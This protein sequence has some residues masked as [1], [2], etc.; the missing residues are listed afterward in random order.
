[1]DRI[2]EFFA[3]IKRTLEWLPIVWSLNDW[4][5]SYSLKVF[6]FQLERQKKFMESDKAV[7]ADRKQVASRIGTALRLMDKVYED[8]YATEW[9]DKVEDRFGE[10]T[11][12]TVFLE[13]D[14]IDP[15]KER[16]YTMKWAFEKYDDPMLIDEIEFFMSQEVEKARQ[17]QK[18]AERLLWDFIHWNIRNW[19]D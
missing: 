19:W 6:R 16:L 3:R 9:V 10:N 4:D 1:M 8:E 2:K 17:K 18:K 12:E 13:L 5:Y 14:D 11:L 7:I 15:G